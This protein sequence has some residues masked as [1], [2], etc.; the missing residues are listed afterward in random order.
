MKQFH[1]FFWTPVSF[2][3]LVDFTGPLKSSRALL[4]EIF[5]RVLKLKN[6]NQI[7][8]DSSKLSLKI[9]VK[10]VLYWNR[11]KLQKLKKSPLFYGQSNSSNFLLGHPVVLRL[12]L[13]ALVV[14]YRTARISRPL[15]MEI[16]LW[17]LKF[18]YLNQIA[19]DLSKF[20][21]KISVKVFCIGIGSNFNNWTKAF[22][23]IVN[24]TVPLVFWD[25]GSFNCLVEGLTRFY[26]TARILK[27]TLN[28]NQPVS[29]K[30]YESRW[31]CIGFK[32]TWS[33]N[34]IKSVL[35]WNRKKLR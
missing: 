13:K 16:D 32:Q 27:V 8:S 7:A 34:A 35:Y 21:L 23:S 28:G 25:T 10:S 19:S 15:L 12:L 14:F 29:F 4:M 24:P 18:T 9:W 5:L 11:K 2:N 26:R 6:L 3:C 31:N 30:I 1:L 33:T 17:V 22:C 20:A